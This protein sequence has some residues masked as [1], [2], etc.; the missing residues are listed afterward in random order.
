MDSSLPGIHWMPNNNFFAN[1]DG[2]TPR[3]L[4]LHG[5]AGGTDEVALGNYFKSTE[6]TDNPTTSHYGIGRKGGIAQYVAERHGAWANGVVTAGHDP[7]WSETDS[8]NPND[9]TISIEH[10]KPSTDNSD[11]LTPE[12]QAASF[13]LVRDI[14]TRNGIPMRPADGQGGI[15]GHSSIDPVNRSR[16]P[17]LYPWDAL[18]AYLQGG[19]TDM[20]QITDPFAARHFKETSAT[21]WLCTTKNI[22]II[23]AILEKWRITQGLTRLPLTPEIYGV[24]PGGS[25]QVCEG[26]VWV[27][28]P[29]HKLD[30]PGQGPV[31]MMHLDKDTPGLRK[32]M[33]FAGLTVPPVTAEQ[34]ASAL[35]SVKAASTSLAV[36]QSSLEP[37]HP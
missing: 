12:Q 14:C 28:D 24:I 34:L 9:V 4:I 18:W 23:G 22:P 16:C 15:C 17:G 5:T 3:W 29:Q 11:A 10:V 2:N 35:T 13:A 27:Y 26:G 37:A 1:R 21:S 30:D 25:F 33:A 20:L 31:Y 36:A 8:P 6:G 32:L 7:W 19:T